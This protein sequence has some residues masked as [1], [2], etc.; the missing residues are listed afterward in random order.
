MKQ[1]R[2]TSIFLPLSSFTKI[3]SITL[4]A[5]FS[6]RFAN[7]ITAR[8]HSGGI[9]KLS[10]GVQNF[11]VDLDRLGV[12]QHESDGAAREY[13]TV[14]GCLRLAEMVR[15]ETNGETESIWFCEGGFRSTA[16]VVTLGDPSGQGLSQNL[17]SSPY[18]FQHF[19][20]LYLFGS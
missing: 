11:P 12:D 18:T 15:Y 20:F 1:P 8:T 7:D 6:C 13:P 10:F 19:D 9:A 3:S 2:G 17:V 14:A 5:L 16:L 4:F